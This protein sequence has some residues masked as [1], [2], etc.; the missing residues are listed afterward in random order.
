MIFFFRVNC[1]A[2]LFLSGLFYAYVCIWS[3][4]LF[5]TH[6]SIYYTLFCLSLFTDCVVFPCGH[7][8]YLNQSPVDGYSGCC[9][10]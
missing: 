3:K 8:P 9:W 4:F 10:K 7:V 5:S 2:S 6:G 1:N